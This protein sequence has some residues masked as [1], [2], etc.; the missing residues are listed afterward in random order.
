MRS[1]LSAKFGEN[2]LAVVDSFQLEDHKTK[3]LKKALA[4]FG[5]ESKVLL[6]DSNPDRNLQL[7]SRNIPRVKLVAGQSVNIHDVVNHELLIFSKE[8]ILQVQEVLSR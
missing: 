4:N 2:C 7:S 1:A 5:A 3:S 8:A 6:V